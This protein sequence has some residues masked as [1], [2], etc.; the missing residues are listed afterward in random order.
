MLLQKLVHLLLMRARP[1]V[2]PVV[3]VQGLSLAPVVLVHS[4]E[5]TADV[6]QKL[7]H[8]VLMLA[9]Y[10]CCRPAVAPLVMVQVL[11]LAPVVL[12]HP[13]EVTDVVCIQVLAKVVLR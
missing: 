6:V 7:V 2:T 1:A 12:V 13:A 4:A 10:S 3:V 11:S 8:V 9:H 5:V